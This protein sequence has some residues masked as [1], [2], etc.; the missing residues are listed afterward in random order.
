[1]PALPDPSVLRNLAL[2]AGLSDEELDTINRRIRKYDYDSGAHVIKAD[3]PGEA[4]YSVLAGTV[5]VKMDAANGKEVI[6]AI[7]G[8]GDIVGENGFLDSAARSEDVVTLEN[9]TLLMM[10]RTVF[11]ELLDTSPV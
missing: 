8:A 3:S 6:I 5:K 9:S 1:M 4:L 7:L 10:D 2:F 11:S